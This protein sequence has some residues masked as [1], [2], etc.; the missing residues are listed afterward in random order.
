[1]PIPE[2]RFY[3]KCWGAEENFGTPTFFLKKTEHGVEISSKMK[4]RVPF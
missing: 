4:L 1:M 2:N 3:N